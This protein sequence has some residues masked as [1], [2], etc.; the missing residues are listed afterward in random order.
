MV[1]SKYFH[2]G[3]AGASKHGKLSPPVRV[4]GVLGGAA[5]AGHHMCPGESRR[6]GFATT[7]STRTAATPQSL[8]PVL[9][10][11]DPEVYL[12]RKSVV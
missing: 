8:S 9:S 11:G 4:E 2:S 10:I 1:P 3:K 5:A 7:S 12:D 6:G